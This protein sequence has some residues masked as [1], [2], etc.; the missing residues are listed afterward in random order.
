VVGVDR[1]TSSIYVIIR[2][3]TTLTDKT[4]RTFKPQHM[5]YTQMID[6]KMYLFEANLPPLIAIPRDD[7]T[8]KS[9]TYPILSNCE[10]TGECACSCTCTGDVQIASIYAKTSPSNSNSTR[11]QSIRFLTAHSA[12]VK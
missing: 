10:T 12:H 2:Y 9:V 5:G 1:K 4:H 7:R 3:P 11:V 8:F 6:G